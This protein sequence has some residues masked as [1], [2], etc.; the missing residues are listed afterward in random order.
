[1]SLSTVH[2]CFIAPTAYGALSGQEEF[3]HVGGAQVQQVLVARELAR[4]GAR[5]SF[6]TQDHGQSE[7][8]EHDGIRVFKTCGEHA[9]WPG[10]R[11]LHPRWTGLWKALDRCGPDIVYQ[12]GAGCETGQAAMWSRARGRPLVFAAASDSDCNPRLPYLSK[13]RDRLLYRFG[14]KHA[15]RI[16]AQ[17][18][19]QVEAF[20]VKFGR[21]AM[22]I[23]SCSADPGQPG[24]RRPVPGERPM[25]LWVGRFSYEKR[26]ELMLDLA[27]AR[28]D[29]AFEVVGASNGGGDGP[30]VERASRI[31][32]VTL[33]GRVP[34]AQM[35]A[36]YERATAL[37]C[38]SQWE[39]FPNTFLEAWARGVPTV[40]TVDPDGA[41]SAHRLGGVGRS[42]PELGGHVDR[43]VNDPAGWLA[44]SWRA[45]QCFLARHSLK[46]AADAYEALFGEV[47]DR[48]GGAVDMANESQYAG[49]GG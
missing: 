21:R 40:S 17:T 18:Q 31:A 19:S 35:G 16:V 20:S 14:L 1:M 15:T 47:L 28:P 29:L 5:V 2:V 36:F 30:F 38:T 26:P 43:L 44:C 24:P 37:L 7:G 9:G 33:H 13:Y 23:R 3:G 27:E 11:F 49:C 12:R 25:V 22:L 41:I 8:V 45:R 42:A 10:V 6:V 46:R 39:G 48:A 34:H 32:N 4:R